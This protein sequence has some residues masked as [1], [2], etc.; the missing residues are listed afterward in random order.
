MLE[1]KLDEYEI[2]AAGHTA[3]LRITESMRQQ[4]EW[5]HGYKGTFSKK[6][7]DSM[8][9]TLGELAVAKCLK[10][11]FNY[12]VNNFRGADLYYKN[13][14]VQVRT[15]EPKP[16]NF[17]IIRQD[18]SAN[19]IYILVLDRCPK[20]NIIGYI[21]SSDVIGK[22]EY[23]TDFGYKDRPKVYA[24]DWQSLFPIEMIFNE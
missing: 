17:L 4:I 13:K 5:G 8:S 9:G 18:S 10:V 20:F 7:A 22:A 16:D 2:L 12:H 11:H 3:L 19:E 23:L 6:I 24:V 15:Q 21:N 14:R 1:I